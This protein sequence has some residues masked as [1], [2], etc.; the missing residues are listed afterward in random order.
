MLVGLVALVCGVVILA[1]ALVYG[2]GWAAFVAG[3]VFVAFGAYRVI[4]AV[5]R[6]REFRERSGRKG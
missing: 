4:L 1:K 2:L 5:T 3:V 6:Y